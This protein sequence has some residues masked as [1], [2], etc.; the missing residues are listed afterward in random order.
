MGIVPFLA[1]AVPIL[2]LT[3]DDIGRN[4][5]QQL[6]SARKTLGFG[7]QFL[8]VQTATSVLKEIW[9]DLNTRLLFSAKQAIREFPV[10]DGAWSRDQQR[11][12]CPLDEGD[13]LRLEDQVHFRAG[14]G[15]AD[16]ACN[17]QPLRLNQETRSA[18]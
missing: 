11:K 15:R 16:D 10:S 4:L 2:R 9:G 6:A 8:S 18:G 12:L 7:S 1:S 17:A 13:L 3:Q 5:L 14:G